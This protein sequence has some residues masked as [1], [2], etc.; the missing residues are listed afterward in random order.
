MMKDSKDILKAQ[1]KAVRAYRWKKIKSNKC[2]WICFVICILLLFSCPFICNLHFQ[3]DTYPILNALLT[4]L[5]NVS[6]GY[7]TGFIVY[8]FI[9]FFPTTKRD[10][11]T[12][13]GIYFNLCLISEHLKSIESKILPGIGAANYEKYT[14]KLFNFLVVNSA[15]VDIHDE[16]SKPKQ[17][18]INEANFAFVLRNLKFA[19][20]DINRLIVSYGREIQNSDLELLVDIANLEENLRNAKNG[21]EFN[22]DALCLFIDEFQSKG[23][24]RLMHI[25]N[26]YRLYRYSDYNSERIKIDYKNGY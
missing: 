8:L 14:S 7:F 15:V 23:N 4:I 25:V 9:T 21:N 20:Q 3:N 12:R 5:F 13:D 17:L 1:S 16:S 2:M 6:I 22:Y 19:F 10:V 11:I 26:T 18:L 24:L